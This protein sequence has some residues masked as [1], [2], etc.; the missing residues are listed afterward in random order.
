MKRL[1]AL[2]VLA[3]T[4]AA[5]A[6]PVPAGKPTAI[7]AEIPVL[8]KSMVV[9][10]LNGV[11]STKQKVKSFLTNAFPKEGADWAKQIDVFAMIPKHAGRELKGIEKDGR[12]YFAFSEVEEL[13]SNPFSCIVPVTD[14]KAFVDG[15]FPKA[16]IASREKTQAGYE[17][18]VSASDTYYIIEKPNQVIIA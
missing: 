11:E 18:I 9:F 16:K 1:I 10:Q 6:A 5:M 3:I 15:L 4:P 13:G 14:A 17:K 2:M 7:P 8:A 12:I